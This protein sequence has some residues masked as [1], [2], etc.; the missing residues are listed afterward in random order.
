[1]NQYPA[2]GGKV[3]YK[4]IELPLIREI[5]RQGGCFAAGTP[6]LTP[7]GAVLI[8]NLR[9]GDEVLSRSDLNFAGPVEPRTVEKVF[10]RVGRIC[11]VDVAGR[12]LMTT[13]EHPFY[14]QSRGWIKALDLKPGDLLLGHDGQT[15]TVERV[16]S[17]DREATVYNLRVAEYHTYFIGSPDW[18]FDV[19]VHNTYLAEVRDGV[20]GIYDDVTKRFITV[21]PNTGKPFTDLVEAGEAAKKWNELAAEGLAPNSVPSI[22]TGKWGKGSFDSASGSLTEHF[23]KHGAEVGAKDIDQYLRKAEAFAQNLR[24]ATKSA[25]DGATPGVTRYK[26]LGKYIDL[27]RDGNIISFGLQ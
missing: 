26:K 4:Q 3:D 27:D 13:A 15:H 19:W 20:A 18:G 14:V 11:E 22:R 6:I 1:M 7:R 24:G 23:A 10:V 2:S 17:T 16:H 9:P 12:C 5:I 25:V 8:E 21:D